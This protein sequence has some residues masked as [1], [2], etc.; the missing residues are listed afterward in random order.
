MPVHRA[1]SIDEAHSSWRRIQLIA[2]HLQQFQLLRN[3]GLRSEEGYLCIH[4]TTM[5]EYLI[6][7]VQ[8]VFQNCL[9]LCFEIHLTFEQR[10]G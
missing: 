1:A 6:L 2:S 7:M 3:E 8:L 5:E 9:H 4:H 10:R